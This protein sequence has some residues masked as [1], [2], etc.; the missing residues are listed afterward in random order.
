MMRSREILVLLAAAILSFGCRES[1]GVVAPADLTTG[2]LAGSVTLL[3]NAAPAPTTGR[4]SL[5]SSITEFEQGR[6]AYEGD[7][8]PTS[9]EERTYTFRVDSIRPGQYF[10]TACFVF[11][12]GEYRDVRTGQLIAASVQRAGTTHLALAF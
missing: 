5:Y 3:G 6:P 1:S 4:I 12:C 2:T 10:V 7:L 11:G 8:T 9:K